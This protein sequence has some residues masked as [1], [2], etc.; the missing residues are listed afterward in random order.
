MK[1]QRAL[2]R[3]VECTL[4]STSISRDPEVPVRHS[5]EWQQVERKKHLLGT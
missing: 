4:P 5:K 1:R 2:E 3:Q